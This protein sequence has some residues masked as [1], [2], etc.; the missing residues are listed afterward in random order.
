MRLCQSKLN[1]YFLLLFFVSCAGNHLP[2]DAF[3][4]GHYMPLRKKGDWFMVSRRFRAEDKAGEPLFHPFYD[5]PNNVNMADK[6]IDY[7]LSTPLDSKY[8]YLFDLPSGALYKSNKFCEQTDVWNNYKKSITRPSFSTGFIP[9]LLDQLGDPHKIIIFGQ[10]KNTVKF[11]G[12]PTS[13]HRARIVGGF[14]EQTCHQ[15][16]CSG[17]RKWLSRLVLVGVPADDKI[18]NKVKNLAELLKLVSWKY[19]K[20]FIENGYGSNNQ[21]ASRSPAYRMIGKFS[22]KSSLQKAF[23]GGMVMSVSNLASIRKS[24]HI[25]YDYLWK[26]FEKYKDETIALNEIMSIPAENDYLFVEEVAIADKETD[27][28][29]DGNKLKHRNSFR[30]FMTFFLQKY[31][32]RFGTCQKYVLASNINENKNRHWIFTYLNSYIKLKKSGKIYNC[33]RRS[34]IENPLRSTGKRRYES[35]E[36]SLNCTRE[37]YE[38]SFESSIAAM[39]NLKRSYKQH[40]RYIEYDSAT[41]GTHQKI[42]NWV[43]DTGKKN[44]CEMSS[45]ESNAYIFPKDVNWN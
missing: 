38:K 17:P 6:A 41:G 2:P 23:N 7:V 11:K 18:F 34:W 36:I 12:R 16:P 35:D 32:K 15:Y 37:E 26:K 24:C 22:A 33:S 5:L 39:R 3:E 14:L 13:S 9:R 19:V 4:E 10:K 28:A 20:A 43:Y 29:E 40:Y 30:G 1:I 21:G 31:A 27:E 45:S 8:G 44:S 42:F 25:L